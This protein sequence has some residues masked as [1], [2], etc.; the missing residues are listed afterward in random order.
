M[1]NVTITKFTASDTDENNPFNFSCYEIIKGA[2]NNTHVVHDTT[3]D[4]S[5]AVDIEASNT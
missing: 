3:E 5:D 2:P 1:L 4:L